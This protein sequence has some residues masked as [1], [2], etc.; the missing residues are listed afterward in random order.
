MTYN[1]KL[2]KEEVNLLSIIFNEGALKIRNQVVTKGRKENIKKFHEDF[3]ILLD[4]I[5]ALIEES[6]MGS[7]KYG[8]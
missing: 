3:S 6:T 5:L 8:R 2:E 1:L 4:K 7:E